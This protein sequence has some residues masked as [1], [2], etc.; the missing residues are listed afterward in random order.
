MILKCF[1]SKST[2]FEDSTNGSI[3][4]LLVH[5]LLHN[6]HLTHDNKIEFWHSH[7]VKWILPVSN[8][9]K[10]GPLIL[11]FTYVW[12][13]IWKWIMNSL[14]KKIVESWSCTRS[15]DTHLPKRYKRTTCVE[16]SSIQNT[17]LQDTSCRSCQK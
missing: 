17:Y 2:C 11:A 7:I 12:Q 6:S 14:D 13:G 9:S 15:H 5:Y 8:S 1:L 10:I 3:W 16:V 4:T